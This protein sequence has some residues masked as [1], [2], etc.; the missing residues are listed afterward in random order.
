ME[1][2]YC[3]KLNEIQYADGIPLSCQ[4]VEKIHSHLNEFYNAMEREFYDLNL[5]V[6]KDHDLEYYINQ[7][8]L[9]LNSSLSVEIGSRENIKIFG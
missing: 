5:N 4:Y 1:E 9:F 6:I 2:P 8:V 3:G 7:G